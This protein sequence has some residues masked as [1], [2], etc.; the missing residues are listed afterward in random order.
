MKLGPL[1]VLDAVYGPRASVSCKVARL[2][3]MPITSL[4]NRRAALEKLVDQ[5][6]QGFDNFVAMRHGKRAARAEVVLHVNYDQC[7]SW[8]THFLTRKMLH[9]LHHE[10]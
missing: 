1:R 3:W 4:V 2:G 7:L 6:I 10:S 8:F 5:S 9:C